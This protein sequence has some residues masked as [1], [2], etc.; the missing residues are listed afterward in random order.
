METKSL[1]WVYIYKN[2]VHKNVLIKVFKIARYKFG[3][4]FSSD[5]MIKYSRYSFLITFSKNMFQNVLKVLLLHFK[6]I[7]E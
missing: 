7:V 4:C 3:D 1:K 2:E 6:N 5:F